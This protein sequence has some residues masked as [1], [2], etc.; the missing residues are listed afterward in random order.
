MT[1]ASSYGLISPDVFGKRQQP[2]EQN[3]FYRSTETGEI[4][5]QITKNQ[6]KNR[7]QQTWD[8]VHR[9]KSLLECLLTLSILL[10]WPFIGFGY[11]GPMTI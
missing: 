9:K 2:S 3:N 1:R 7:L 6:S 10:L 11:F 4:V 5:S 8:S